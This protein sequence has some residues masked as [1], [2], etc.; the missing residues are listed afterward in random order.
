MTVNRY[1]ARFAV[2]CVSLLVAGSCASPDTDVPPEIEAMPGY[3]VKMAHLTSP[4]SVNVEGV[5]NV[6]IEDYI[7]GVV[8]CEN[9][10][11][12]L[13]ALKAQ[14]VQARSFLYYKLFVAGQT[15][16]RNSQADQVYSCSYRPNGPDAIH[17]QAARETKGQYLT[18]NN[19]IVASFYV[20]GAI[21]PNPSS[22]DPYGSCMPN[23]GSDPTNTQKWV[24]YNR[25][26][27]GCNIKM[28]ALGW[29]P[30]DCNR[31]PQN[32]GCASQNGQTCLARAGVGYVDMMKNFYGD[33]IK[34]T[35]GE[36]QCGGSPLSPED[37]FCQTNG[38]GNHCLNAST[39]IVCE[40]STASQ[41]EEC[42]DGCG[43]GACI[44]PPEPTFCTGQADGAY[45]DGPSAITCAAEEIASTEACMN[46]CADGSCVVMTEPPTP[47]DED[48][49]TDDEVDPGDDS[50]VIPDGPGAHGESVP[51]VIG[52]SSGTSGPDCSTVST[53]TPA[54]AGLAALA[55]L[56]LFGLRRRR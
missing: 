53:A 47:D 21:P 1:L 35:Y 46:G 10:S 54:H 16:I 40:G 14:A 52:L 45:C 29:V 28:T 15:T 34:V 36:G 56:G 22:A 43:D 31:N 51:P 23:G 44:V 12:P 30:D 4:C 20:A 37:Q 55:L 13:E 18:W 50:H 2:A 3:G 41:T 19:E 38:N 49:Q 5:G 42:A 33:D 24:T 25:G 26:K 48:D 7:A 9:G 6:P 32:R 11:A 27:S 8:A 17:R 39:R